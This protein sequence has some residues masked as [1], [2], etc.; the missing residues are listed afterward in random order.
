[1]LLLSQFQEGLLYSILR[2]PSVSA[3]QAYKDSQPKA[4]EKRQIHMQRKFHYD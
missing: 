3:A 4:E 1:M 2:S